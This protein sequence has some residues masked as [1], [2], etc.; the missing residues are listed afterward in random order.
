ME[1]GILLYNE[2]KAND[3][4]VHGDPNKYLENILG[5]RFKEYRI[6][7]NSAGRLEKV[8]DFPLF[9]V[10]E[11]M[12]KCNLTCIMCCHSNP[13][14]SSMEYDSRMPWDMYEKIMKEAEEHN[15]PSLTIGG[16]CEP[17]LDTRLSEMVA[18]AKKSDFVDIMINTNATLLIEKVSKKLIENGLTR[19]RIGFDGVKAETYERIRVGAKFEEVKNNILN[20]I[21]L[22]KKL[23]SKLPIVRISCVHLSTN[24]LEINDFIKY[25]T[26][27]VEYVSIQRYRPH[28][29]TKEHNSNKLETGGN[30]IRTLQCSEPWERL[31]IRGNGDVHI[32]CQPIYGPKL[33]NLKD[34][35]LY[36]MWHSEAANNLRNAIKELDWDRVPTCKECMIQYV[37]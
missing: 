26:P 14:N 11:P 9:L 18:L 21:K 15:C 35:S 1:E 16:H 7:W 32:C 22:R 24:D 37:R 4:S 13:Q 8:Y 27:I 12:W 17:L 2:V 28:E 3:F 6:R 23:N 20:F 34:Y 10:F 30:V 36:E 19:L 33:G 29:I 5:E 31:Y 25:W